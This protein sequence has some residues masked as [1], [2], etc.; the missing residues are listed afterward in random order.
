M[1]AVRRWT[2]GGHAVD[3]I[4]VSPFAHCD[5]GSMHRALEKS[6]R[7]DV[8]VDGPQHRVVQS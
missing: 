7:G 2:I 5:R 1:C 8:V 4:H 6:K 3:T